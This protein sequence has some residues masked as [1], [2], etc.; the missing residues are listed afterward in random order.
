MTRLAQSIG[1][2]IPKEAKPTAASQR[3]VQSAVINVQSSGRAD[4]SAVYGRPP[5]LALEAR[6]GICFIHRRQRKEIRCRLLPCKSMK[7]YS[8]RTGPLTY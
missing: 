5:K 7:M 3:V 8:L 6:H 4:S 2:R 1:A